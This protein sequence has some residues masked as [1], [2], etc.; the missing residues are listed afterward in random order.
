MSAPVIGVV[1]ARGA[2]GGAALGALF[3][4]G[5]HAVRA[6][7]RARPG[8]DPSSDDPHIDWRTLDL[9]DAGS[10]AAFCRGC[11]VVLNAAGPSVRIADRVAR[12]ADAAGAD[13]VDAF[14]DRALT[15]P[16][17]ARP[18]APT[19]RVI[20]CAGI[21]PGLS[22][23]VPRWLA[24]R[25]FDRIDTLLGW[26]GGREA[27]TPG[28]AADVL[29]STAQGFG[30]SG[31]AWRGGR[32]VTGAPAA[33]G[34]ARIAGYPDEVHVQPFLSDEWAALAA[35]LAIRDAQWH[36]VFASSRAADAIGRGVARLRHAAAD[37]LDEAAALDAAIAD[38]VATARLDLAG[39]TPYYRLVIE[40]TGERAG[41]PRRLRAVLHA[42]DSYRLTGAIAAAAARRLVD[43][44]PAP[45]VARAAQVLDWDT[46]HDSLRAAH[47][48]ASFG[49][50]D[51]PGAHDAAEGTGQDGSRIEEGAL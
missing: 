26:S 38:L 9:D 48:I 24:A 11:A 14:G 49:L 37:P 46:L 35:D 19:R 30:S 10:L 4:A 41:R 42:H 34:M 28:A 16:L 15:A 51:L 40:A 36:G 18:L 25:H 33:A 23:I 50:V 3:A 43:A 39:Q 44:P 1:G 47:A 21:Y 22:A 31:A 13:Y 7:Y 17:A 5:R 27:C 2:V 32:L 8:S 12:A 6:G 29:L 20:H 45:G